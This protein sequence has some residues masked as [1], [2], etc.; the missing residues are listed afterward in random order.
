MSAFCTKLF[1]NALV[2]KNRT[3]FETVIEK[4]RQNGAVG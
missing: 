4:T 2:K 1:Q 3:G